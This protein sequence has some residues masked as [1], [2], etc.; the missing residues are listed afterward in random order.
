M[1]ETNMLLIEQLNKLVMLLHRGHWQQGRGHG[2]FANPHRGQGRVLALLKLRPQISQREL[3]YLLDMRN[4]SLS[5]LL[6]KLEKAGFITRTPSEADRRVM[7]ITLTA[8]GL[9]AADQAEKQ[10]EGAESPFDCL[11]E[12]EQ[13]NLSDYLTRLIEHLEKQVEEQGMP[14][15]FPSDMPPQFRGRPMPPDRMACFMRGRGGCG[16]QGGMPP[17]M[18]G[19]GWHGR[20]TDETKEQDTPETPQP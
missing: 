8:E 13:N 11:T 18:H 3:A 5:E 9:A 15:G 4:Q 12:E 2:P 20:K 14:E 6:T 10:K 1:N 19:F 16:H 17:P 7:D